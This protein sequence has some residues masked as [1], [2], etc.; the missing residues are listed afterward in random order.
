MESI[1]KTVG[2]NLKRICKA[3]GI[4]N[5]QIADYMGVTESSVSHWFRGDNSIDID[6]LH[7]LCQY[8]NVSL[9]QVFGLE[10]IVSEILS[11]EEHELIIAYRNISED[12]KRLIRRALKIDN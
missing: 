2:E 5:Y 10:P 1:R 12:E 11:Q 8:L 7:K 3:K 6:N 9:D 4:K